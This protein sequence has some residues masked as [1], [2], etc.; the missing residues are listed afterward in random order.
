[1][2]KGFTL[3]ELMIV[4]ALIAIL[5]TLSYP[6]YVSF[7]RKADRTEAQVTLLD[8]ANRQE[9][10][11]ADNPG[12]NADINPPDTAKYAYTIVSTVSSFTLTA[13]ALGAQS[14][15]KEAGVTCTALSLDQAGVRGPL[16]HQECW[17]K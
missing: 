5:V 16:G 9:L 12:Y 14:D 7:V 8:W 17:S 1:M 6:S 4:T 3:I 2:N 11:R 13:T 15:D 10:W